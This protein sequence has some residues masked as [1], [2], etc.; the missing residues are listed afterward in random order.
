MMSTNLSRPLLEQMIRTYKILLS[1]SVM[2]NGLWLEA[3]GYDIDF[4]YGYRD[5]VPVFTST[6]MASIASELGVSYSR[7]NQIITG[8]NACGFIHKIG[9]GTYALLEEPSE[10]AYLAA[11]RR[12]EVPLRRSR[13]KTGVRGYLEDQLIGVYAHLDDLKIQ[14]AAMERRLNKL[15]PK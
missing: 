8:M 5:E 14:M 7:I 12:M 3:E 4:L 9:R 15:E 11:K 6:G 1:T 2:R 13:K 10:E